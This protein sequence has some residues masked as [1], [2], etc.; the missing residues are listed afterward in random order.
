MVEVATLSF[1]LIQYHFITEIYAKFSI[2]NLPQSP[3][4][5]QN[6]DG[7]FCNFLISGQSLI[8]VNFHNSRASDDIYMKFG[9]VTKPGKREKQSQKIENDVML[10]SCD[11]IVIFW[12]SSFFYCCYLYL[13]F[14]FFL[15]LLLLYLVY[16][17]HVPL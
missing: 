1:C 3:D 12:S 6:S 4:I 8:K 5:G 17:S 11:I 15:N 7:G 16:E 9:L 2:C 13:I 10:A 14:F